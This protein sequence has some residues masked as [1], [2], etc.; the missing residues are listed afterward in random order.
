MAVPQ[1][2]IPNVQQSV[3]QQQ[4]IKTYQVDED[5]GQL[6]V[7]DGRLIIV[8]EEEQTQKDAIRTW[9]FNALQT[10]K[11]VPATHVRPDID[12]NDYF[13]IDYDAYF[14]RVLPN[15]FIETSLF[16]EVR[17]LLIRHP[18]IEDVRNFSVS[19]VQRVVT[20]TADIITTTGQTITA[21]NGGVAVG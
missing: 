13:G 4:S 12:V 5:S 7:R 17:T 20:I 19:K 16:S 3:T 1:I 21:T 9:V 10:I 15:S 6:S 8:G 2:T 14:G 18:L 11:G